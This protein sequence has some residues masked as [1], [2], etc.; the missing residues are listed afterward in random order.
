MTINL[1]NTMETT[2]TTKVGDMIA[3]EKDMLF[4]WEGEVNKINENSVIVTITKQPKGASFE[5]ERTV[6]NHR[7]YQV[8]SA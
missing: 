1:E 7:R 8:I 6:V 5:F 4:G 3:F 2:V